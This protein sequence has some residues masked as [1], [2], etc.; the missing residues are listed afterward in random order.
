MT[1]LSR[2]ALLAGFTAASFA[3]MAD[4]AA[5]ASGAPLDALFINGRIWD[6]TG[7]PSSLGA[8]GVRGGR[9]AAVGSAAMAAPRMRGTRLVDLKG[10]FVAPGFIDNHTHFVHGSLALG[11]VDLMGTRT[12]AELAEAVGRAASALPSGKWLLGWGWDAE[13]WGGELP[14]RALLDPVAPDRPVALRRTDGHVMLVNSAALK[15]AGIDRNTPDPAGGLI[16]RDAAGQPTGILKDMA[17]DLIEAVVPAPSEADIDVAVRAGVSLALSKGVTQVHGADLDWVALQ[18]FRRLRAKGEPGM[19]FYALVPVQDWAR[20]RDLIAVE[21]RGDDWVRWG[22]VKALMDGSLGARTALFREPYADDPHNR[23]LTR[24]PM[25]VLRGWI[26]QADHAG[27]QVACH[28]IGDDATSQMLDILQGM[29]R[30]NG[31]RDR[32]FRVEHAQH[33]APDVVPRFAS[34]GAIASMQPYHAIDDGRWA[35]KPLGPKRL[36]DAWPARSLLDHGACVTFGSD[37][38]VAPLDP[39]GGIA[40]AV[41]RRTTDGQFPGGFVPEQRVS[42]SEALTAYTRSNAYAGFQEDRLGVLAPGKLA[43]FVVLDNDPFEVS[44]EDLHR[45]RVVS[46]VVNGIERFAA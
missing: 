14:G 4:Q 44:A 16:L 2:R 20:L 45:L 13:R 43:D 11:R 5:C 29:I 33:I 42:V 32:R 26:E 30:K 27:F 9:I 36:H 6:G 38:P 17:V 31:Q 12:P 35:S 19:R 23:G 18:S 41:L 3:G 10:R 40:A 37:W 1:E 46:T 25:E 15:L 7:R 24:Q 28:S 34:L 8:I 39:V 21:G 22:G